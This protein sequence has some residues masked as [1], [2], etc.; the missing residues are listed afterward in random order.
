MSIEIYFKVDKLYEYL[1]D[2]P[3]DS[4]KD[5]LNEAIDKAISI[6]EEIKDDVYELRG[7][8]EG[9]SITIQNIVR[10]I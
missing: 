5:K 1:C 8:L 2:V 3:E 6:V 9:V 10:N 4:T 7:E